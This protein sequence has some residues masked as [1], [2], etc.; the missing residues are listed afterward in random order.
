MWHLVRRLVGL[1][2]LNGLGLWLVAW[3][4]PGISVTSFLASV[5]VVAVMGSINV[6]IRPIVF[7]LVRGHDYLTL[8]ATLTVDTL[9]ILLVAGLDAGLEVDGLLPAFITGLLLT[10]IQ[11]VAAALLDLGEGETFQRNVAL[12]LARDGVVAEPTDEP[13]VV[14]IQIDGLS[15]PLLRT[16]I[17]SGQMPF[18]ASWLRDGSHQ[19]LDWECALP[20]MTSAS[21]AGILHGNNFDIPAFRWFEKD[22]QKLMVSNQPLDAA[23]IER[24]ASGDHDLLAGAGTSISNLVSGR[25]S[26]A[27]VTTSRLKSNTTRRESVT[28]DLSSYLSRPNTAFRI[29][30]LSTWEILMEWLQAWR[31]RRLDIQPRMHRGGSFP[32]LRAS[33]TVVMPDLVTEL[34]VE[35]MARGTP[36]IYADLLAYDEVAHHAGPE[37][38]ESIAELQAV[39][40]RIRNIV[41]AADRSARPYQFVV[42]SDHGQSQGA[43]F[44]ERYGRTLEELVSSFVGGDTDVMADSDDKESW[45]A[46]NGMLTELTQ[47]GGAAGTMAKQLLKNRQRDGYVQLGPGTKNGQA[48]PEQQDVVVTA[49]GNLAL[50][51]FN[52]SAERL[53]LE[54]IQ[55][56]YPG[57]VSGLASHP[58]ISFI[59]VRSSRYGPVAMGAAGLHR[60][61]DGVIEG[62]DP[63]RL[64]GENTAAHLGRLSTFPH[65]GDIVVNSLYDPETEEVAPFEKLIGCH[66]GLGG[67][68]TLPFLLVPKEWKTPDA[69]IVGAE[70]VNGLL[71]SWVAELPNAV[72]PFRPWQA[73]ARAPGIGRGDESNDPSTGAHTKNVGAQAIDDGGA[74]LR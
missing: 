50:I 11:T 6:L 5:V 22:R 24:R 57:L 41:Q 48:A 17:R 2:V 29:V 46:T 68:Q 60:L 62:E 31:Q 32:L 7:V 45:S 53:T 52:A 34:L 35:E 27:M 51:Y 36:L 65:V 13:G 43:T 64:F 73:R 9:T 40:F 59:M 61:S 15:A 28:A 10:T 72:S 69:P 33:T 39:D 16:V 55:Q 70:A 25:A 42:L 74:R 23:E 18:L 37:R 58:G 19:L 71:R 44:V 30:A 4:L 12:R 26:R 54:D 66:G 49:S 20:S 38:P 63:L 3:L 21:Q 1:L 14:M 47:G 8:I 56:L 67:P